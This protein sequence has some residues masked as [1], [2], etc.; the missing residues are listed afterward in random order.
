MNNLLQILRVLSPLERGNLKELRVNGREA[1]VLDYHLSPRDPLTSK[2]H[3]LETLGLTSAHFDKLVSTILDKCLVLLSSELDTDQLQ[4]L[5][6]KGLARMMNQRMKTLERRYRNA[7]TSTTGNGELSDFF[8][9]CFDLQHGV[10]LAEWSEE[11]ALEYGKKYLSSLRAPTLVNTF[12]VD[13]R[14]LESRIAISSVRKQ[15]TVG[16]EGFQR[17]LDRL[18]E[19]LLGI[20][21]PPLH[22]QLL[23]TG[24]MFSSHCGDHDTAREKYHRSCQLAITSTEF[25]DEQRALA[26]ARLIE[27][28]ITLDLFEES[29]GR[30]EQLLHDYV[31]V[32][33]HFP[34]H[35]S[36]FVQVCF[37]VGEIGRAEQLI[38]EHLDVYLTSEE[39]MS[40]NVMTQ[41]L[42]ARLSF[43]R[44]DVA[45]CIRRINQCKPYCRKTAN[46]IFELTL[47]I[48][49]AI[50]HAGSED[51]LFALDIT[52][53]N[54]RYLGEK[55]LTSVTPW[56]EI[57]DFLD[58][59]HRY[60]IGEISFPQSLL[61]S[62][63]RESH[64]LARQ[65]IVMLRLLGRT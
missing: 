24:A 17:E 59:Y 50:A 65:Y 52:K 31:E 46:P 2:I 20:D 61:N 22:Y 7:K 16:K 51:T 13:I 45:D 15:F 37:V 25:T 47:R 58:G 60:R 1:Q 6:K 55:K 63:D 18:S 11:R 9:W 30:I 64:G 3:A 34:V 40:F 32:I 38:A 10:S 54:A 57:F 62:V 49:E 35:I 41:L 19:L 5:A 43:Y 33:R 27:T 48:V 12:S 28:E 44:G 36:R 56:R 26:L 29:Y 21:S 4:F 23:R 42:R 39:S 8:L 14:M 53:K